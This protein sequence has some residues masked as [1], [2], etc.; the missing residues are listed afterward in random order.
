MPTPTGKKYKIEN[1]FDVLQLNKRQFDLFLIDL[2]EW[3]NN[4]QPQIQGRTAMLNELGIFQKRYINFVDD[5]KHEQQILLIDET[6][7]E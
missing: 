4:I 2:K 7:G 6:K 3:H 1:I 5:G